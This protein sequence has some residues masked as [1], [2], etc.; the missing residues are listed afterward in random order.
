[1]S[2]SEGAY[3]FGLADSSLDPLHACFRKCIHRVK[4]AGASKC[5]GATQGAGLGC[6]HGARWDTAH[7]AGID[8]GLV[9]LH[10]F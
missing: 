8:S 1:M 9:P 2:S 7:A 10:V 6:G 4:V 5:R 3:Y